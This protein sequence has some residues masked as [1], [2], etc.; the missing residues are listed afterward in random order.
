[1]PIGGATVGASSHVMPTI[2]GG[3]G[4]DALNAPSGCHCPFTHDDDDAHHKN[5]HTK[6]AHHI[7]Y[8][9]QSQFVFSTTSIALCCLFL[10][11]SVGLMYVVHVT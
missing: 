9:A 8:R 3:E 1:M 11:V 4:D 6:I 7:T 10:S 5:T 2:A